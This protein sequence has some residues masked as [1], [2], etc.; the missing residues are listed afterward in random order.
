VVGI[1]D[2]KKSDPGWKTYGSGIKIPDPQHWS[3][4]SIFKHSASSKTKVMVEAFCL[5][6]YHTVDKDAVVLTL[7]LGESE[8][9]V[10]G[11]VLGYILPH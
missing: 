10:G 2:G 5:I 8:V 11:E 1:R 7:L 6:R 3:F 4:H 9:G